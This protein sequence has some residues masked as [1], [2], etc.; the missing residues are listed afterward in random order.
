M[1]N[2]LEDTTVE[3]CGFSRYPATEEESARLGIN[4]GDQVVRVERMRRTGVRLLSY[5]EACL[6]GAHLGR[7]T[8]SEIWQENI[9]GLAERLGL[10]LGNALERI[11]HAP[12]PLRVARRLDVPSQTLVLTLDRIVFD[13]NGIPLEWRVAYALISGSAICVSG[14][15]DV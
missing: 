15:G 5:E 12:A 13:T 7:L 9:A 2:R 3:M 4:V 8:D 14:R 1:A 6:P 10:A 11:A